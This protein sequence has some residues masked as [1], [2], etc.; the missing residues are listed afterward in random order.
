MQLELRRTQSKQYL[1]RSGSKALYNG[2]LYWYLS[3]YVRHA[4]KRYEIRRDLSNFQQRHYRYPKLHLKR[5]EKPKKVKTYV[6][7]Q[8]VSRLLL[9]AVW[10]H[11]LPS[12]PRI[13][14]SLGTRWKFARKGRRKERKERDQGLLPFV[15]SHSR[16]ALA[17]LRNTKYLRRRQLPSLF[18][19]P[20][21]L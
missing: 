2:W 21:S 19:L 12:L 20:C 8:N 11:C 17:S 1:I 6:E 14:M 18:I 10:T 9:H 15:T 3:Y 4:L 16:F 13:E 7:I 5:R